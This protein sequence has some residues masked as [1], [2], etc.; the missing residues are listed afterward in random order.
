M[1]EALTPRDI[2][3]VVTRVRKGTCERTAQ[4]LGISL[5]AVKRHLCRVNRVLGVGSITEAVVA[6][7]RRDAEF[8][9]LVSD[10]RQWTRQGQRTA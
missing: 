1:S 6:L 4:A 9:F 7:W 10:R 5:Y 2:E 3:V 8:R